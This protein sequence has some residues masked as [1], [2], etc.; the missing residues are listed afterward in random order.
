MKK[1]LKR[2]SIGD[3]SSNTQIANKTKVF[4]TALQDLIERD[5]DNGVY[6]EDNIPCVL[7]QFTKFLEVEQVIC[8]EGIFRLAGSSKL[9]RELKDQIN[10][11]LFYLL[12]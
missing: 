3:Q 7:K 11:S 4:G 8:F 6:E 10:Q 1:L 5:K 12:V 9:N 2:L